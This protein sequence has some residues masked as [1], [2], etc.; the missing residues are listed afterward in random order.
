MDIPTDPASAAFRPSES[1]EGNGPSLGVGWIVGPPLLCVLLLAAVLHFDLDTALVLSL[2]R[3]PA[4]TSE[5]L[6][7]NLTVLGDGS[8]AAALLLPCA[9]RRPR[10][11]A[12]V[13]IAVLLG[14]L[15]GRGL[16]L[17]LPRDR[18]PAVLER[19]LLA[20]IGPRLGHHSFPSGHTITIFM[21]AA[22]GTRLTGR[23]AVRTA[24]LLA[25]ALVGVSRVVVGAHWPSDVLA[26]A[27]IGW[28]A[29]VAGHSLSLRW[30]AGERPAVQ[31]VL[32]SLLLLV[33]LSLAVDRQGFEEFLPSQ[34]VA[35][36]LGLV[37]GAKPW[38][39][40]LRRCRASGSPAQA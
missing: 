23:F 24:L 33:T 30:R 29:G 18:P 36:T 2:N 27:G 10:L 39:A 12:A 16:V 5:A 8:V 37:F 28:L 22:L 4:S 19:D 3:W 17:L 35:A 32:A 20:V 13:L 15:V 9:V 6:W 21:A 25:A 40:L 7:A 38:W 1:E 26:G 31:A 14:L 34:I 11:L